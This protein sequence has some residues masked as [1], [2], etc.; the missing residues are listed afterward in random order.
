MVSLERTINVIE[1][2]KKDAYRQEKNKRYNTFIDSESVDHAEFGADLLFEEEKLIK[3]YMAFRSWDDV[4]M[5]NGV[6]K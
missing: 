6:R 5:K 1:V 2:E 4:S 3:D